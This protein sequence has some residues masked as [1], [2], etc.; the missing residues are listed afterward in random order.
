VSVDNQ[1]RERYT[2]EHRNFTMRNAKFIVRCLDRPPFVAS[3]CVYRLQSESKET[4]YPFLACAGSTAG[5]IYPWITCYFSSIT[6]TSTEIPHCSICRQ[7]T[8]RARYA[9]NDEASLSHRISEERTWVFIFHQSRCGPCLLVQ[10][11]VENSCWHHPALNIR[12]RKTS[13]DRQRTAVPLFYSSSSSHISL[14]YSAKHSSSFHSWKPTSQRQYSRIC[15]ATSRRVR[16]LTITPSLW[17]RQR[18][19]YV[20]LF[21]L[22]VANS[23]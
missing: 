2:T 18:R 21:L 17:N 10:L 14:F 9:M 16:A 8:H 19:Y 1:H 23:E 13:D 11:D 5:T 20:T 6:W 12:K 22:I 4:R 15:I 7:S 3:I